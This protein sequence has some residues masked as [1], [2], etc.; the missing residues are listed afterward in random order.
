[1]LDLASIAFH[2]KVTLCTVSL[3]S[4]TITEA[5]FSNKNKREVKILEIDDEFEA[6]FPRGYYDKNSICKQ[7]LQDVYP[8]HEDHLQGDEQP[9]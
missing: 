9:D 6:L 2:V 8:A 1:M 3:S 7:L 4:N 5:Y